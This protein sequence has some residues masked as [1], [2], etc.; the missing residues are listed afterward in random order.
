MALPASQFLIAINQGGRVVVALLAATGIAAVG[1]HLVL[2]RGGSLEGV[3]TVMSVSNLAY[4]AILVCMSLWKHLT[5]RERIRYVAML[6]LCLGSNA[7]LAMFASQ[8]IDTR[9]SESLIAASMAIVA[10]W[11]TVLAAAW[12]FAGWSNAWRLGRD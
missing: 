9:D 5:A 3:A 1:N 4:L 7:A 12:H 2:T 8:A 6:I 10:A 11:M